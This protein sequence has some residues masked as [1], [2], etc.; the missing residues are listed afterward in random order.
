MIS[1]VLILIYIFGFLGL[2]FIIGQLWAKK[3]IRTH[4]FV[5]VSGINI[6]YRKSGQGP[7]ALVMIHG[8]FS[9]QES[10]DKVR[11]Y[12]DADYTVYSLDLPGMG[13]T[14]IDN[15]F[16]A[17]PAFLTS[18]LE[19]IIY[20]FCQALELHQPHIMGCSLGGVT[21]ALNFNKYPEAFDKCVIVSA[22]MNSEIMRV[23]V[24]K[25][26][27]LAPMLNLFVNPILVAFTH[28]LTARPNFTL[29]QT[30]A[31]LSKFRRTDHFRYSM[32]Y[33]QAI[34]KTV[35]LAQKWAQ[36]KSTLFVWGTTDHLVRPNHF[37]NF[38]THNKDIQFLKL[39]QATH[40]PMESHPKEFFTNVNSFL[41]AGE[42]P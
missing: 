24:F 37:K 11:K 41:S 39:S 42:K 29:D 31:I 28:Y 27:F 26:A 2:L 3:E 40:H 17:S 4:D 16:N 33:L 13:E 32:V 5:E 7:K 22:P 9:N 19:D 15:D 25:L 38:L 21:A 23:P 18:S 20:N 8:A 1:L 36:P 10:W 14:V 35:G 12:F 30:L 34:Y 6:H